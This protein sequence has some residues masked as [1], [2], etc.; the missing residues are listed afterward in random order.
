VDILFTATDTVFF[1]SPLQGFFEII[2]SLFT[3]LHPMFE[4]LPPFQGFLEFITSLFTGFTRCLTYVRPFRAFLRSLLHN[5]GGF[6]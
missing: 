6:A 3:G 4:I 2:T 1:I 5:S